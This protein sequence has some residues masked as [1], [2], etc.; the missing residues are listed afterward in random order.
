VVVGGVV[1]IRKGNIEMGYLYENKD[2]IEPD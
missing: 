1:M 2:R